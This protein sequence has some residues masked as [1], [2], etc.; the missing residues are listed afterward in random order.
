MTTNYFQIC[1]TLDEARALYRNLARQHHPDH[2]G[3]TTTMQEINRQW[4]D[5][6]ANH[7]N[8][9]ERQRQTDAHA[10]GRKTAADYHNLDE[11]TEILRAKIM[12]ALNL[13]LE[14]ELCGLWLWVTGD[15]RPHKEELKAEKFLWS[16]DKS[17]W[18]YPGIPSFNRTRRTMDEIRQ[19]HGST[20]FAR[21]RDDE[22]A[23][24]SLH[25]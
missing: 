25:A 19:M 14:V 8:R 13:G 3:D 23:P 5:F 12:Y 18:Y 11:V 7:A 15:T 6:Q 20:I 16:P 17:A 2:G 24:Q 9:S 1:Q 22:T 10:A 21:T 4:A